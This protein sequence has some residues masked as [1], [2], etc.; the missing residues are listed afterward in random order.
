MAVEEEVEPQADGRKVWKIIAVSSA[1]EAIHYQ[2]TDNTI[3]I[4]DL[5]G[6]DLGVITRAFFKNLSAP[7]NAIKVR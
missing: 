6:Q 5:S 4:F 3:K 2:V 1:S 7:D